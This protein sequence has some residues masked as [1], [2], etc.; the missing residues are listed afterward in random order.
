VLTPV[1]GA[2]VSG[3]FSSL[4]FGPD[5]YTVGT[6]AS[7]VTLTVEKPFTMVPRSPNFVATVATKVPV[8]IVKD[9][10]PASSYT[11]QIDWGD[12]TQAAG[13]LTMNG[14]GGTAR[15]TH[16]YT[17]TGS[18]TITTT[19]HAGDGTTRTGTATATVTAGPGRQHLGV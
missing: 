9:P 8:A 16:T 12:G 5:A 6:T 13:R 17:S 11:V 7:T 19:I 2:T 14:H 4:E 3:A 1:S 10:T 18:F 15:G